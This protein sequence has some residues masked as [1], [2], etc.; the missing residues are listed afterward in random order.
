VAAQPEKQQRDEDALL[1]TVHRLLN[2][3]RPV[4]E[5]M[6]QQARQLRPQGDWGPPVPA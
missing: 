5:K 3:G 4:P 1:A 2:A 6:L